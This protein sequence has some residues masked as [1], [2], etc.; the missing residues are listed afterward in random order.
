MGF[1]LVLI[2]LLLITF[3]CKSERDD[4]RALNLVIGGSDTE[5]EVVN[6]I[7]EK[8]KLQ[9]GDNITLQA[10]GS[11]LGINQIINGEVQMA[12]SS[13]RIS[14]YELEAAAEKGIEIEEVKFAYDALA[15]ISHP[16]IKIDS[17]S[18]IDLGKILRGEVK[19]WEELGY[20]NMPIKI[21]GRDLNSGTRKYIENRFV[22]NEGFA[23]NHIETKGNKEIIEKVKNNKGAIGYVGVGF[24]VNK[25]GMPANDVW[26]I[27]I[28]VEG[29]K[30]H[31]PYELL[32]VINN[33]Y[34]LIRPLYQYINKKYLD[35]FS[36]FIEFELSTQGQRLVKD[37]GF[38]GIDF[39]L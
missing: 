21:Y 8:Y 2:S 23:T 39:N 20:Q 17:L 15:F 13:R 27:P 4:K 10:G 33:E 1:R 30:A 9:S 3:S 31:S 6:S 36:D 34:D 7:L 22:R 5:Y 24:I 38:Y 37:D 19:N 25:Y 28:Y 12:N 29:G 32:A 35:A 16:S 11:S 18:T 14:E 26:A